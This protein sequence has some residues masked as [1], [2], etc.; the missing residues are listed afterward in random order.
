[1]GN[2]NGGAT[3]AL[4]RGVNVGGKNILPMKELC[5]M[6]ADA[7]CV[8]VKNY[9]QSGNVIFRAEPNLL[10]TLSATI[11]AR[12]ADRFGFHAPVVLRSHEDLA[13]TIRDNPFIRRGESEEFL[14]VMFLADK[15]APEHRNNLDAD[16]SRP[17]EFSVRGR[18]IYL[19]LPNGVGKT[20]LNNAWFDSKLKTVGTGRNWRTVLKLFELTAPE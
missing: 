20:K 8:D 19:Y 1:M 9:I 5:G 14:H 16:R 15:P 10:P 11:G 12:I 3:V 7:G 17:D 18:E 4:L 6:F 13:A 2:R